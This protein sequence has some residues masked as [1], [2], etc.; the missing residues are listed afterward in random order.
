LSAIL[1]I[2]FLLFTFDFLWEQGEAVKENQTTVETYKEMLGRPV[3]ENIFI[4][5]ILKKRPLMKNYE[6]VFGTNKW[7]WL[8]P[9][10][11]DLRINALELLY[12]DAEVAGDKNGEG[13]YH[14]A[15]F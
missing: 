7:A 8:L 6:R 5:F 13:Y 14:F 11:P 9:I 15:N 2:F 12:Y 1:A 3:R 10:A 4:L